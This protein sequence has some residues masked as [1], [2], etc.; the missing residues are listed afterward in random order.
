M[1]VKHVG[2]VCSSCQCWSTLISK[3]SALSCVRFRGAPMQNLCGCGKFVI[4]ASALLGRKFGWRSPRLTHCSASR[5]KRQLHAACALAVDD[6]PE[7][8]QI[9]HEADH[10]PSFRAFLDFKALKSDLDRHVQNCKDRKSSA[11]PGKVATLY[12][13]YCE[14]QKE[15]DKIR[16][17]RN[18][19]AKAMKVSLWLQVTPFLSC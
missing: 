19:N 14:A 2:I 3:C 15:V 17:D 5:C 6:R 16:E 1:N 8:A 10:T 7:A 11:N 9:L 12:D 13:Q 18:Q 4:P